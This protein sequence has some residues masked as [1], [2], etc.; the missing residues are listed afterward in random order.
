MSNAVL[1]FR[2]AGVTHVLSSESDVLLFMTAAD[3]S[4]TGRGTR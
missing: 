3:F 1:Q 2:N 4:T